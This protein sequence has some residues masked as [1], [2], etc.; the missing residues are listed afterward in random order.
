M[1]EAISPSKDSGVEL[2]EEREMAIGVSG[3]QYEGGRVL[4]SVL[5]PYPVK[6]AGKLESF[7][8]DPRDR[9]FDLTIIPSPCSHP[10]G[11]PSSKKL[12]CLTEIF[13][14]N[15]HYHD[16]DME[17]VVASGAW[18]HHPSAQALH[19]RCAHKSGWNGEDQPSTLSIRVR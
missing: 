9:H 14:P 11:E 19:W 13:L 3:F 12:E 17:I 18:E 6:I 10:P 8:F 7:Q 16:Q 2:K 5:R 4:H 15:L 1:K